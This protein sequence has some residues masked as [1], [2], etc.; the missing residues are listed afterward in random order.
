MA[1]QSYLLIL[2]ERQAIA[3]VLEKQRMAFPRTGRPQV[4]Q[5]AVGDELLVY[6]ARSAFKNASRDRGRVIGPAVV[7]SSVVELDEPVVIADREFPRGCGL[8]IESLAPFRAGLE[9]RPLVEQ[10]A[11][12]PDP[13][14]WSARLRQSLLALSPADAELIREKLRPLVGRPADHLQPYLDIARASPARRNR[15]QG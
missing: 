5:L 3:W 11:A 12:F 14:T 6:T 9:L 13:R 15:K 8:R 7:T 1:S 10:L 4:A 2:A